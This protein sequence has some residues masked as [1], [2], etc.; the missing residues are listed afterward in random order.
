MYLDLGKDFFN[1]ITEKILWISFTGD[2]T[3]IKSMLEENQET[4]PEQKGNTG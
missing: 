1:V 3:R 2:V 4:S